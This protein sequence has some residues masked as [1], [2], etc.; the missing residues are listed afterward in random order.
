MCVCVVS[1]SV[2]SNSATPWTVAHQALLSMGILLCVCVV[3]V[4]VCGV[5]VVCVCVCVWCVCV[6]LCVCVCVV[7]CSVVSP[8]KNT[9]GLGFHLSQ[10]KDGSRVPCVAGSFFT[11]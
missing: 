1:C 8:G 3:C 10:P 5:C 9:T 4:C 2:V 6:C 7:S 11:S